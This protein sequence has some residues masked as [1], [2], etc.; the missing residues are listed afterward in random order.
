MRRLRAPAFAQINSTR[1]RKQSQ[2]DKMEQLP[3]L[4]DGLEVGKAI[5]QPDTQA[6]DDAETAAFVISCTNEVRICLFCDGSFG[7]GRGGVALVSRTHWLPF[8]WRSG[9]TAKLPYWHFSQQAWPYPSATGSMAMEGVGILE[10][11]HEANKIIARDLLVLKEHN[12][13][14]TVKI[15]SDCVSMIRH[16]A[17]NA[18]VKER[19]MRTV[20]PKLIKMIK[21]E[22]QMLHGHGIKLTA[23]LH[24]CPRNKVP[25][26]LEA[27]RLAY[28]SMRKCWG[29]DG[30]DWNRTI[31]SDMDP[32]E[33]ETSAPPKAPPKTPAPMGKSK[34]AKRRATKRAAREAAKATATAAADSASHPQQSLP[35]I[36][37]PR[38]RGRC[39]PAAN[40]TRA[41]TPPLEQPDIEA[42][43]NEPLAKE[44]ATAGVAK[45]KAE[46][47]EDTEGPNKKAK[48]SHGQEEEAINNIAGQTQKL[49]KV[50]LARCRLWLI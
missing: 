32:S 19:T 22:I 50:H 38:R 46:D 35:P 11:F 28:D 12:G 41:A 5:I 15:T 9:D 43:Q 21:E 44:S 24:W 34:A 36:P 1:H 48:V 10:A 20:P 18:V 27:D 6:I 49:L 3:I 40:S 47:D 4:L 31:K 33:A 25:Q 2:F 39:A 23:E 30:E 13:I 37:P 7:M 8:G 42:P 17:N 29:F 14:V 45:R 16:V 26:L